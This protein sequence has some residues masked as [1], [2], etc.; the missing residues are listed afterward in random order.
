M[1]IVSFKVILLFAIY[2]GESLVYSYILKI[3]KLMTYLFVL[4]IH[5]FIKNTIKN[6]KKQKVSFEIIF[7]PYIS[8]QRFCLHSKHRR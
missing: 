2:M 8:A 4:I 3:L 7:V 1:K 6:S 5:R